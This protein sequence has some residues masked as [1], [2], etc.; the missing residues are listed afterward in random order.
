MATFE[1]ALAEAAQAQNPEAVWV[2]VLRLD[3][4]GLQ[5]PLRACLAYTNQMID[6]ELYQAMPCKIRLPGVQEKT[7]AVLRIEIEDVDRLIQSQAEQLSRTQKPVSV[8]YRRYRY[9]AGVWSMATRFAVPMEVASV[10]GTVSRTED[11]GV[12]EPVTLECRHPD[13]VNRPF[14]HLKYHA[15]DYP[16]L[17]V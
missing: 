13:L 3:S 5:E 1:E 16:G 17:R 12:R 14:A 7:N 9:L 2:D 8:E 10:S 4:E 15:D 6:G 11:G